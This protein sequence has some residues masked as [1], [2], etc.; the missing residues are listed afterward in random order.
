LKAELD[1][2]VGEE[3]AWRSYWFE[4]RKRLY[5]DVRPLL[6]QI[7]KYSYLGRDRIVRVLKNEVTVH[8]KV[9]NTALR[10]YLST[11]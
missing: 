2:L 10:I 6:F 5:A 4:A 9:G 7:A 3:G 1:D 11:A 8:D